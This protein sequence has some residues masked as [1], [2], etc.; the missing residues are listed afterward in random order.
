[1]RA[2]LTA[3]LLLVA[4]LSLQA[5]PAAASELNE[6]AIAGYDEYFRKYSRRYFGPYFDWRWFKAQAIAESGLDPQARSHMGAL[7]LMQILPSTFD[8][9]RHS[10]PHFSDIED[11]RWNIAA[12]IYYCRLLYEKWAAYPQE[13]RLAFTFASYNA[14]YNRV[15][16]ATSSQSADTP[17][18]VAASSQLPG[19]TRAYVARIREI[20][21]IEP[22]LAHE[23]QGGLTAEE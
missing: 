16:Q 9:I 22:L 4:G 15:L 21:G 19:Q 12:G 8:E 18:W 5:L 6:H 17:D 13:E 7:G 20:M 23:R 3:V 10:R 1:M 11:P 2:T 14:G